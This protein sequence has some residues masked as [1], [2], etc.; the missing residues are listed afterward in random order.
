MRTATGSAFLH[1][2]MVGQTTH[3]TLL[4]IFRL[5]N[6]ELG[7]SANSKLNIFKLCLRTLDLYYEQPLVIANSHCK[8][9]DAAPSPSKILAQG[10]VVGP[11]LSVAVTASKKFPTRKPGG[12][13]LLGD[14]LH[15]LPTDPLFP[16]SPSP[17]SLAPT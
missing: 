2:V 13:L 17:T 16:A 10:M 7:V 5:D 8:L 9:W 14:C 3:L 6:D 1:S 12:D 15:R 11:T 4:S